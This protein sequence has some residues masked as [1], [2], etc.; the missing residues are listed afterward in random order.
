MKILRKVLL[1]L[2][3]VL[4]MA[5]AGIY[6]FKTLDARNG[7]TISQINCIMKDSRGYIWLGTPAGLYRYDGY[8][9]HSFQSNSQDGSSLPWKEHF[10]SRLR[11]AIVSIILNPKISSAT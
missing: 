7:L 9:F 10:L 11:Q 2:M 5:A 4:P 8:T 1:A 3:L 6:L